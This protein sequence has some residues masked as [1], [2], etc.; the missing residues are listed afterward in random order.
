MTSW[1]PAARC[2]A[3]VINGTTFDKE[4][5]VRVPRAASMVPEVSR[6]A[7]SWPGLSRLGGS[8]DLDS[9]EIE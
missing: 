4:E 2:C 6:G 8:S 3:P 1:L 7:L 9:T 5:R